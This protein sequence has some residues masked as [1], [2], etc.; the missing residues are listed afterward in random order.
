MEVWRNLLSRP[1]PPMVEQQYT[2]V[3]DDCVGGVMDFFDGTILTLSDTLIIPDVIE[4]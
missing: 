4:N 2:V 3:P 1:I